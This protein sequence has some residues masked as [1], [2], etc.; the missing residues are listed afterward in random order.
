MDR[1]LFRFAVEKLA[2][3]SSHLYK[4]VGE[5]VLGVNYG[6]HLTGGE[7]FINFPLLV[8][9]VELASKIGLPSIF[10]E[11]NCFWCISDEIVRNR[12]MM[13]KESGL[14]G[15]LVSVNPFMLE[16]VDFGNVKRCVKIALDVFGYRNTMVYHPYFYRQAEEIGVQGKLSFEEYLR[17]A[18][19]KNYTI[20]EILNPSIIL[21]MGRLCYK[22][23]RF[24][25][26]RGFKSYLGERCLDELTR[27]W[28]IHIDCYG[29][30]VPGYCGGI[31]LGDIRRI[32]EILE[33]GV[34]LS[35]KPVLEALSRGIHELY[36]LSVEGYGYKPIDEG[37]ISKC[38]LCLDIR[39]YLALEVGGFKELQPVE[40]YKYI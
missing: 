30:Y 37:Y 5:R 16:H 8:S 35:D 17:V 7:P 24:Y 3:F 10:V 40:L 4:G 29:N 20:T 11:T 38:H 25:G 13:L 39:R 21:P 31:S 23:S 28:H 26:K 32:D 6:F 19:A 2:S 18:S 9:Y 12:L 1:D 15:I 36:K 27:P 33:E 22:L 34:N 14:H